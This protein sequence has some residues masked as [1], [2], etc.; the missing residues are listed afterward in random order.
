MELSYN[1]KRFSLPS[2]TQHSTTM[3]LV[4]KKNNN[5]S[6]SF[7]LQS[8]QGLIERMHF[9]VWYIRKV[10]KAVGSDAAYAEAREL[11][12]RGWQVHTDLSNFVIFNC[13]I[14]NSLFS[15]H[16]SDEWVGYAQLLP[17]SMRFYCQ[18]LVFVIFLLLISALEKGIKEIC[19][20]YVFCN[21]FLYFLWW[22]EL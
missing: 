5:L 2:A 6:Q 9:W 16:C 12:K 4:G 3:N 21:I 17:L 13:I 18:L 19:R 7:Y 22:K 1:L 15:R 11:L 8:K 20:F 14:R 10:Y